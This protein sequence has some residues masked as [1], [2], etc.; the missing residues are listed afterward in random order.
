MV[1]SVNSNFGNDNNNA[2]IRLVMPR[3]NRANFSTILPK[4]VFV[5]YQHKILKN[6]NNIFLWLKYVFNPL[7]LDNF[8]VLQI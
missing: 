8:L 4:I 5:Y 3:L 1:G 7:N 2:L 6:A